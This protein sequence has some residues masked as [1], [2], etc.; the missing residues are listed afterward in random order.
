MTE[1]IEFHHIVI[2]LM[3]FLIIWLNTPIRINPNYDVKFKRM[4]ENDVKNLISRDEA[5]KIQ[6]GLKQI[7][8]GGSR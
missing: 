5:R 8:I 1:V 3:F 6:L 7:I 2:L 4:I